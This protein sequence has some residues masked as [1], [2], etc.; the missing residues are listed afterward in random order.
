MVTV[1]SA[2]AQ[3]RG[4]C[5]TKLAV[6]GKSD[7]CSGGMLGDSSPSVLQHQSISIVFQS[8]QLVTYVALIALGSHRFGQMEKD[9]PAFI[10]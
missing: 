8:L 6:L 2:V 3:A 4:T 7:H 1:C 5:C 10:A 9:Q